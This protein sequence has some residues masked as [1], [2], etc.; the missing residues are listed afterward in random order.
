M[1][2]NIFYE[3]TISQKH[4]SLSQF[5]RSIVRSWQLHRHPFCVS[6]NC[7]LRGVFNSGPKNMSQIIPP[8]GRLCFWSC[9]L[10]CLSVCLSV[11]LSDYLNSNGRVCTKLE[12][13]LGP[14]KNRLDFGTDP[15]CDSD[16]R[17]DC[18]ADPDYD[19]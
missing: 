10:V 16:P 3:V 18:N 2:C 5:I 8:P 19:N 4:G 15:D 14:G 13:C 6:L 12:V 11:R 9:R 1:S 7:H 17:S